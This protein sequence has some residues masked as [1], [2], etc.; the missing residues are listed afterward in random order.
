MI[1]G[2]GDD[3]YRYKHIRLNFS[4]NIYSDGD[5][6]ALEAYLSGRFSS[7]RNYPSP[8][9]GELEE[10]IARRYGV[11]PENVL[12]TSGATDAIYLIAQTLRQEGSFRVFHPTFSEYADACRIFGYEER[13]DGNLCW[14]CNPNN[15]TGEVADAASLMHLA[16]SCKWLVID[17]SYEDY[18]SSS[19]L[20]PMAALYLPNVIQIR[21]MTKMYGIPGLRVGFITAAAD[22]IAM[23]RQNYRPWAV[24]SLSIDAGC[25]LLD[26][27]FRLIPDLQAYLKETQRLAERLNEIE[28]I[29]VMPTSTN[30][31][32][33]TIETA[34]AA[35]LKDYLA[36]R[37]GILIRD[38][39]NFEGLT[40]RHF[41]VAAQ[42]AEA[43]DELVAAIQAFMEG[44]EHE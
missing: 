3:L 6:T 27:D 19:L 2:H 22:V 9:A 31:M 11:E 1:D 28:G 5:Y 15:P 16:T 39:S 37:W 18:T 42:S 38:A 32:L 25:W 30:F 33:C 4:S 26:H 14:I 7:V 23:L 8:S 12:V 21:S 20:S 35:D 43:D 13:E 10:R 34:L 40:P 17:Q 29:N 36:S 24:S 44:G 41:R